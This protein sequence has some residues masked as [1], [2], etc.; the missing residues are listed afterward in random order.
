VPPG[1]PWYHDKLELKYDAA[2]EACYD[3]SK[4][5]MVF[6]KFTEADLAKKSG[7]LCGVAGPLSSSRSRC[8]AS[9]TTRT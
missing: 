6:M 5:G 4:K 3:A 8:T 2:L 7:E 1:I 9:A